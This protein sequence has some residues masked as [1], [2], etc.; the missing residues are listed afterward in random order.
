MRMK[1]RKALMRISKT[2]TLMFFISIAFIVSTVVAEEKF[3]GLEKVSGE[4][5]IFTGILGAKKGTQ[6][7]PEGLDADDFP[8]EPAGRAPAS[9]A[10]AKHWS[11]STTDGFEYKIHIKKQVS[12]VWVMKR[13][14]S[15]DLVFAN[16]NGSRVNMTIPAEQFYALKNFA[17]DLRAPASDVGKCKDNF[18]QLEMVDQ[19]SSKKIATCLSTK[20]KQ[21]EKLR[22]FGSALTA[23]IR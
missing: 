10:A 16:N 9:V 6:G 1:S 22:E 3:I 8:V 19:M 4:D 20:S 15:Y 23:Y 17:T 11:K 2:L 7:M 5:A 21:A 18:I 14:N 13:A 12:V